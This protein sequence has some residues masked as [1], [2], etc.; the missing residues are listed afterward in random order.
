MIK[1]TK[2]ILVEN[3]EVDVWK[4]TVGIAKYKDMKI[5]KLL[6]EILF[7]FVEK[8]KIIKGGKLEKRRNSNIS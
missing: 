3:V 5:G 4:K 1:K 6:S 7:V 8:Q 2:T